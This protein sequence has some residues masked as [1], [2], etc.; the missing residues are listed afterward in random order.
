MATYAVILVGGY[1]TR[2]RPLSTRRPKQ[3]LPVGSEPLI[4]YQLRQLAAVGVERVVLATAHQAEAFESLL[5]DGSH[6]DVSLEYSREET[7]MG[8]GGAV[9]VALEQLSPSSDDVIV[10]L[11]GD[12]LSHHDLAH[13]IERHRALRAEHASL[14]ATIHGRHVDDSSK[15]GLLHVDGE[16]VK[17]FEEKPAAGPAGV[18]NAGTYVIAPAL[19]ERIKADEVVSLEREVFPAAS[20]VPEAVAVV[21]DDADFTDV[22]TPQ[23]LLDANIKWARDRGW[24]D[25]SVNLSKHVDPAASL[26]RTLVMPG[27]FVRADAVC[28]DSVLAPGATVGEGTRL[29]RCIVADDALIAPGLDLADATVGIA[30]IVK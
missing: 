25:E 19:I 20:L 11:N 28:V 21:V 17:G 7:P 3:L 5:G 1:G 10:V 22:G 2:M 16:W 29:T 15:Y 9:R 18:V 13:H 6:F 4:G 14:L 8:T 24:D 12:L 30:E 23:S 26:S 27:A